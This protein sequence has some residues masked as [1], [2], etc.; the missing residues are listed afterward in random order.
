[1][2]AGQSVSKLRAE[3]DWDGLLLLSEVPARRD[4]KSQLVIIYLFLLNARSTIVV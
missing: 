4:G 2:Q 3:Q 1:M